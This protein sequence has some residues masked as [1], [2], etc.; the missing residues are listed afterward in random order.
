[1]KRSVDNGSLGR[2]HAVVL[3]TSR[4]TVC[5]TVVLLTITL[6]V[7]AGCRTPQPP[8]TP[9]TIDDLYQRRDSLRDSVITLHGRF[10]GWKGSECVLPEY[11]SRQATR[12]D[13]LFKVGEVCLYVTGGGPQDLSPME[14]TSTGAAITLEARLRITEDGKL[15]LEYVR[16]SPVTQ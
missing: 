9:E 6:F 4:T 2:M 5:L 10:M 12:S 1:M 13:W 11:A 16:S 15:L 7:S 3:R 14:P 8:R